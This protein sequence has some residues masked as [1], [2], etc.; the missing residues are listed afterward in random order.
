LRKNLIRCPIAIV[1]CL[2]IMVI[3]VAGINCDRK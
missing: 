3:R 2:L 1:V